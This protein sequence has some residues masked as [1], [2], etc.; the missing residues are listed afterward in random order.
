MERARIARQPAHL[1]LASE[2]GSATLHEKGPG[3]YDPSFIITKL[4]AKVNR[5][6]AAGLLERLEQR[7]TSN[8]SMLYQG[9]LRDPT[10]LHYFSIGEYNSEMMRE[11]AH[12]WVERLEDGEPLLVMM[13]AK[14]RWYQT[15]EGAVYTS[16]RPE[17]ACV[18][19]REVYANWLLDACESTMGRMN[20]YASSLEVEPTMDAYGRAGLSN[21]LLVS[22]NHY[23]D[24]DVEPF[25]LN[26]M[27]ALDIAEGRIEAATTPPPMMSLPT[28]EEAS[29]ASEDGGQNLSEFLL[30]AVG[31]L[32]QGEGVDYETILKNAVAR[33]HVRET[34][35]AC[36]DELLESGRLSE[37]RFGWFRI[38]AGE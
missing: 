37:P 28:A 13:T 1:L 16:L 8:G 23:G 19:S 34:A 31:H 11:L 32:D 29:A 24:I 22:R 5:V 38:A 20:A 33:G 25:K 14:T 30:Q 18:V 2:F 26:L 36:L 6:V 3:E 12:Q 9:Q 7:D 4:G 21:S 27:Q 17:E 35:E 15:D 10:G